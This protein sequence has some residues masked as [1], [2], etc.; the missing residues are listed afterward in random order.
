[1]VPIGKPINVIYVY[2]YMKPGRFYWASSCPETAVGSRPDFLSDI[3]HPN[4]RTLR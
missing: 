2:I 3:M 4:V 1:M